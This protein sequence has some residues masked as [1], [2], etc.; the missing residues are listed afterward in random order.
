MKTKRSFRR[1]GLG[2]SFVVALII[3]VSAAPE[4]Q[5]QNHPVVVVVKLDQMVHHVSAGFVVRAIQHANAINAEAVLLELDTPGGLQNSMRSIIQSIFD[6]RVPVITYVTPSGGGAASA[7][8]FILLAGDVAVMAPGTTTGAAHPVVIGGVNIG[9]TMET[10]IENDAAA[11]IRSIADKRG[12][13]S[14]EAEQGVRESRSFTEK[15]A[16]ADHLIDAVAATPQDIFT[17]FDGKT[18]R[19]VNDTTT[20]L[21]L[22]GAVTEPFTMGN[23]ERFFAWIADPNIAFLLGAIG[24][25][26]LYVE[27]THPGLIAPGVVGAVMVV[28][29]MYAFNL[30]PINT[31][32]ILLIILALV[33]FVL[34]A[35]VTS[36]GALAAGGVVSMVIGA[37]ILVDSPFPGARIRLVTALSVALPLAIITV[38]LLRFAIAA[39]RRK[40]VTGRQGMI[41]AAGVA[42]TDLDPE[43]KVMV[44]GEIWDARSSQTILKGTRVRVRSVDGLTLLVETRPE[45]D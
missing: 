36:H 1:A 6:S 8:F 20:T 38:I 30:L 37:M 17:Q 5:A 32:G 12:R 24:L 11:Y 26:C 41:D 22:A 7:G 34:E 14:K 31:L 23:R 3:G 15:E 4:A 10:K 43:G 21:H 13:N 44:R 25:A 9:K 2:F 39:Q 35:T 16:L 33:L 19:R 18:V 28:M 40:T 29:A 27:F 45:S 42:Q